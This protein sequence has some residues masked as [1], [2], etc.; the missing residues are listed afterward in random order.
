MGPRAGPSVGA[1]RRLTAARPSAAVV[2]GGRGVRTAAASEVVGGAIN[3]LGGGRH[4]PCAAG[5][6]RPNAPL[7]G[8]AVGPFAGAVAGKRAVGVVEAAAPS[9]VGARVGASRRAKGRV[10]VLRPVDAA[11]AGGPSLEG[12]DLGGPGGRLS[13]VARGVGRRQDLDR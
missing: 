1:G 3:P 9:G 12:V 7:K 6:V 13:E 11:E 4:A 2:K 10:A 5:A 8:K